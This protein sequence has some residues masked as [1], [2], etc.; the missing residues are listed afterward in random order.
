MEEFFQ[1]KQQWKS[2]TEKTNTESQSYG[3]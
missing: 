3:S 1:F 2:R